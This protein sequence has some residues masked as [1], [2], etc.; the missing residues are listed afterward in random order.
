MSTEIKP[1][2]YERLYRSYQAVICVC[3]LCSAQMHSV[4][5]MERHID[6]CHDSKKTMQFLREEEATENYRKELEAQKK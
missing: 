3:R 4:A 1:F 5:E 2:P 6:N